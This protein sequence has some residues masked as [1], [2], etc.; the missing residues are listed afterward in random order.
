MLRK[1]KLDQN[2]VHGVIRIQTRYKVQEFLLG[3]LLRTEYDTA[4]DS[5]YPGS[6]RLALDIRL[7]RRIL[8]HKY[9]RKAGNTPEPGRKGSDLLRHLRL[10][11]GGQFFSTDNHHRNS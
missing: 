11:P 5:H 10:H 2:S 9:H 6:L 3:S 8:A 7:A 4:L 1:R